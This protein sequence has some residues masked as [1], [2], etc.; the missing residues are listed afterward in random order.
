MGKFKRLFWLWIQCFKSM[1]NFKIF[2]PFLIYTILQAVLLYSL[3]N[4]SKPPFSSV[5]VPLIR[6]IF[7]EQAL[8]YPN[9]YIILTPLYSQINVILSGI[10]GIIF[11]GMATKLFA[12]NFQNHKTSLGEA[13]K[14]AMGKYGILFLIWV[15]VTVLTLLLIIGLPF[16]L[17]EF[18]QP[19]YLLGRIFDLVGLL[20]AII[21]SSMFAYSTVLIVLERK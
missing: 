16:L 5:L 11:V 18:L 17:K 2:A 8:H 9:F 1:R 7:G 4:F 15:V 21:L 10:F 12:G 14:T 20:F 6:D 19:Q 3:I 13:F